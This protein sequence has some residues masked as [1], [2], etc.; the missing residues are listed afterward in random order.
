MSL[1]Q[2]EKL[3]SQR[4]WCRDWCLDMR[5]AIA[6]MSGPLVFIFPLAKG[7]RGKAFTKEASLYLVVSAGLLAILVTAS[8]QFSW[9]DV[10]S[11]EP[12]LSRH[13][14]CRL[15]PCRLPLSRSHSRGA[16]DEHRART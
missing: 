15:H 2:S 3:T 16:G 11:L 9:L 10:F 14:P 4:M 6:A 5:P 7:L 13:H 12:P 8:R 1:L